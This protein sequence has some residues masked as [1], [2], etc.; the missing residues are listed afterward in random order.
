[1]RSY[2]RLAADPGRI[3]ANADVPQG[4]LH[5]ALFSA[6]ANHQPMDEA[7][8]YLAASTATPGWSR[9]HVEI[10]YAARTQVVQTARRKSVLGYAAASLPATDAQTTVEVVLHDPDQWLVSCS[11]EDLKLGDNLAMIG[12]EVVQFG[13]ATSIGAGRFLISRLARGLRGTAAAH[14]SSGEP[15]VLIER[16]ALQPITLP[17]WVLQSPIRASAIKR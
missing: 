11:E 2:P 1:M 13:E 17:I 6:P 12:N 4:E 5:V 7:T 14:H 8:V 3:V 9:H 15:F 10:S 16:S